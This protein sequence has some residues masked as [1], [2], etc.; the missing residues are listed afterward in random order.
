MCYMNDMCVYISVYACVHVYMYPY[1]CK[2]MCI[3]VQ[4]PRP[5]PNVSHGRPM[6][7][8]GP[9]RVSAS[10][11]VASGFLIPYITWYISIHFWPIYGEYIWPLDSSPLKK[12]FDPH[13]VA[14]YDSLTCQPRRNP[15]GQSS[16][17]PNEVFI[18]LT[19]ENS[20]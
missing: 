8:C 10:T 1:A 6:P 13:Q 16:H 5:A 14:V 2:Y 19:V 20:W 17:T 4:I 3:Y 15:A 7:G 18:I 9:R 12:Q 11:C